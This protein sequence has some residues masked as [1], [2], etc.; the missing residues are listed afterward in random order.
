M[1]KNI[2]CCIV[3]LLVLQVAYNYFKSP[4][5]YIYIY[6]SFLFYFVQIVSLLMTTVLTKSMRK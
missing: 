1:F 3:H 4:E 2:F 6:I 5:I